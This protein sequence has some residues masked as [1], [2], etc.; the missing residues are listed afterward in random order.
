[1]SSPEKIAR[2]R[3]AL[4]DMEPEIWR[5]VEVPLGMHLQ[6]VFGW[7]DSHLFEFRIGLASGLLFSVSWGLAATAPG[8]RWRR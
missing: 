7:H 4:K 6:A 2:I 5:L 3:I 1:M 8:Q